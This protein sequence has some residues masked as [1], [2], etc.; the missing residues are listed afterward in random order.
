[1]KDKSNN[2][3]ETNLNS[4]EIKTGFINLPSGPREVK[5]SVVDG[6]AIFEGDIILGTVKEMEKSSVVKS[7]PEEME[8]SLSIKGI[9]ITGDQYLWPGGIIPYRIDASLTNQQRVTDAI[10]H[11]ENRTFIRFVPQTTETNYVTFRPST[12]CSSQIG[13]QGGQQFIN[14]GNDCSTGNTIHEIGHTVGLYH[15]QSREDRNNFVRIN[16]D[17]IEV[18]KEDNFDQAIPVSDDY[19][20]YDYGS[21][22]HYG[23]HFFSKNDLPTIEPLT[24]G[25]TIGQRDGLSKGDIATVYSLYVPGH[26]A[27]QPAWSSSAIARTPMNLDLFIVGNDGQV[28]T[29]WWHDGI[30][31]SSI[32]DNWRPLGGS[33]PVGAPVSAVARGPM[34]LDLFV[35]GNDGQVYTSWWHDGIDWSSITDNWR[36]LGGSFPVGAPVSAVARGPMNLDLFVVGNDGQVYTSWWHDGIDWSSITDNWRPLGGSFSAGAPV[37]AVARGPMNLDL[38]AVGND[39]QVYTS[40]WHDGIDWSSITDN[41]RPLGGSFSVGAPVS[42]VARGPMNLDLFVVGNDGQVYT[43]W[44]HDGID[45]SS[46][47]NNWRPLGGSFPAG[48]PVS[49]VA[50]G[51]MNLDLFAV[52]ND[53]QVYTSWWHDG[54]DWSSITDNW[55]PLG[56]SFPVGSPVSAVARGPMNLDLFVVGN[57]GQVYTSWWHDGIDWSSITNNWRPL[58]GIISV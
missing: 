20:P 50:R 25:V 27:W 35:V 30:D 58:G 51:P 38:F 31:W 56:G 53:G 11:W 5:Y 37:S 14:L 23:T 18:G 47:T 43:S 7:S 32:T 12:S 26:P 46:I 19:G 39:G 40:W 17:N 22:M 4:K 10:F 24:P 52:G 54:I 6:L 55:R 21:I 13:M 8:D 33:F 9:G 29:S 57:D 1:M 15:E 41:W 28:Y 3:C 49:A 45:W 36:P 16:W 2:L 44:W 34:N 42:A 48:A